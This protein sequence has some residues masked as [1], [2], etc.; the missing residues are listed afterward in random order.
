MLMSS[1]VK[2]FLIEEELKHSTGK[3]LQLMG[4]IAKR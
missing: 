2:R 3:Q 1:G 4:R